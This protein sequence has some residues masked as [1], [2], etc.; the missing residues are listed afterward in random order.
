M[1]GHIL[2][3]FVAFLG[4]ERVQG[5]LQPT[6]PAAIVSAMRIVR[7]GVVVAL[8]C[9][10]TVESARAQTQETPPEASA[11]PDAPPA[12]HGD[13]VFAGVAPAS[14]HAASDS[15]PPKATDAESD[16]PEQKDFNPFTLAFGIEGG[17][18]ANARIDGGPSGF[19]DKQRFDMALSLG[20]WAEPNRTWA[21]GLEYARTGLG[22]ARTPP[23]PDSV[24]VAYD[25]N[26]LWAKARYFALRELK[27]RAYAGLGLGLS[28]EEV[29]ANG[30]RESS[31][32]FNVP[33]RVFACSAVS[34]PT[35]SLGAAAGVN[36]D[37]EQHLAFLF[38]VEA[39]AQPVTGD[40]VGDCAVASG[41]VVNAVARLGFAYKFDAADSFIDDE[42]ARNSAQR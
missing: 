15:P 38:Q 5:R 17:L 7:L 1:E 2:G 14:V 18:G 27:Y 36:V 37:L 10:G 40:V 42:P 28:I 21:Y 4:E 39:A 8:S 3:L 13:K 22:G 31:M 23:T 32:P 11:T 19:A 35:V 16:T 9:L 30:T 41:A 6:P 26:T 33:P 25:L 20:A 12:T 24:T 34:H 29:R